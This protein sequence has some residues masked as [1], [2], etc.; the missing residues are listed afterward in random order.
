M[1][2]DLLV[3][4]RRMGMQG[5]IRIV[6]FVRGFTEEQ[7]AMPKAVESMLVLRKKTR[8]SSVEQ[9]ITPLRSRI[10]ESR[11]SHLFREMMTMCLST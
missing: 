1:F 5:E 9:Y 6:R 7:L 11:W 4:Y 10:A 8:V 3:Q 2:G